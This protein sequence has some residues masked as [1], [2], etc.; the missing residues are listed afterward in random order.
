LYHA[1]KTA[2]PELASEP[3]AP[4]A[5]RTVSDVSVVAEQSLTEAKSLVSVSKIPTLPEPLEP[6]LV[7]KAVRFT[8]I[9]HFSGS[10]LLVS[11]PSSKL[12]YVV[13]VVELASIEKTEASVKE[14]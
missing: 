3:G 4:E 7:W 11:R 2:F 8:A 5:G 9:C 6:E 13:A 1:F 14:A 12:R 10:V